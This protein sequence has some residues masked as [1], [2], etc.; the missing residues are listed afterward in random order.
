MIP[1]D[2]EG[3]PLLDPK[4]ITR[5][6]PKRLQNSCNASLYRYDDDGR[7]VFVKRGKPKPAIFPDVVADVKAKQAAAA[8]LGLPAAPES[9]SFEIEQLRPLRGKVLLKW[10]KEVEEVGGIV[11][12]DA[13][14]Q[15][16]DM[17]LVVA[18]G[19]SDKPVGFKPNDLVTLDR[20]AGAKSVVIN[21]TTYV[22]TT[23]KAIATIVELA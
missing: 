9:R 2:Q 16:G 3:K 22:M 13:H 15:R 17:H 21:G 5:H 4:L 10:G 11:I 18:I 6:G 20:V 7:A 8:R 19:A 14:R 12:P 23:Q 1:R